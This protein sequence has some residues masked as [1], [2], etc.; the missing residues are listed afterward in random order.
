MVTSGNVSA[1]ASRTG[2]P[3]SLRVEGLRVEG[4]R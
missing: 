2:A 3:L 1:A 4:H